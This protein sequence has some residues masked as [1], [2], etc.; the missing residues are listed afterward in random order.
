[1][2]AIQVPDLNIEEYLIEALEEGSYM[3]LY[4]YILLNLPL[5]QTLEQMNVLMGRLLD[6]TDKAKPRLIFSTESDIYFICFI[7][8]GHSDIIGNTCKAIFSSPDSKGHVRY[9]HHLAS[10]VRPSSVR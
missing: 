10:I 4:G 2:A 1:M 8:L 9:C 3:L 6:W 5:C 7:F